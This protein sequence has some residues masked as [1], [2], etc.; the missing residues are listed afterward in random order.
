M[1]IN[2][3]EY[4]LFELFECSKFDVEFSVMWRECGGFL[5]NCQTENLGVAEG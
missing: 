2:Y 1:L 3:V 4:K 5:S